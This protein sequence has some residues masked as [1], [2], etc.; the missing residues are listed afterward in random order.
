MT[1]TERNKTINK[2]VY[3]YAESLGYEVDMTEID[4][5]FIPESGN[6]DDCIEYRRSSHSVAALNWACAKTLNDEKLIED[7]IDDVSVLGDDELADQ[8][9]VVQ[10]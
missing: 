5:T 6:M 2:L 10:K 1:K 7:Y 4:V 3:K 8:M 9:R